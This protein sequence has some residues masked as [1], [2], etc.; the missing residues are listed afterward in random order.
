MDHQ[1]LYVKRRVVNCCS[2]NPRTVRNIQRLYTA[3]CFVL[4]SAVA[5]AQGQTIRG[6]VYEAAG[7][8]SIPYANVKLQETGEVTATNLDGYFQFND[9]PSGAYVVEV[10]YMGFQP[11]EIKVKSLPNRPYTVEVYMK[12]DKQMLGTV[13]VSADR[14]ERKNKVNTSVV[15]LSP[16]T[17]ETFSAGGDPDLMKAL[18]VLPGVVTTGDQGGQLY[19]RGGA[20]IQ[21]LVMLDGMIIYNPFHS[22]GFFSVFDTDIIQSADV[23]TA[24]FG[25]EYGSRNSSVMDVKT[26][27]GNRKELTGKWYSSTFMS[28]LLLQ[29]PLGPKNKNGLSNTSFFVSGKTSY[30]REVAPVLYPY[31]QT[32]LGGLPFTFNDVY[33]KVSTQSKNGSNLNLSGFNFSD[34]VHLDSNRAIMWDSYGYGAKFQLVPPASATIIEGN[35][36]QS[37]YFISSTENASQPRNS[38]ISGFNAGLDFTYFMGKRD[39]LKYGIDL[40]G[41]STIFNYTN[42]LGLKLNQS[43][44]TTEMAGFFNYRYVRDRIIVEPGIRL[45]YYGSLSELSVEPRFGLKYKVNELLRFKASAGKYSQNLVAANS[46][47]D[48]VNLFY[49]FLSGS[50]DLPSSFRDEPI[51]SKLQKA[52][53]AV[54][55][56]EYDLGDYWN[57]NFE[58]YIKDFSQITNINRNKLYEDIPQYQDRPEILRKDFIVERGLAYGFDMV[59]KYEYDRFY[60]WAVYAWSKVT[61]DDGIQVYAPN[62]DRRHNINL[63][64][65][66]TLGKEKKWFASV[67]WNFGS[68]FPF[69]PTAGYYPGLDFLDPYGNPDI[70]FDYTTANGDP[71]VLYG[72]LNSSRLPYYHRL[73][74]S[75]KYNTTTKYG[76]LEWSMGATNIYNR[77]NIFYYDRVNAQRVDQLPIL[78]TVSASLTF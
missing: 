30:L 26:K 50:T 61:R 3:L 69:T 8:A 60:L 28:K 24:G 57:L 10:V 7:G 56:V 46:D 43:E 16:K 33:A 36:A 45:H 51:T 15:K 9:V 78:P 74:A 1:V 47:R 63:V 72:N 2:L 58:T 22:I 25:A 19:I 6:F 5:F 23:Y 17:I 71:T 48:V 29:G 64:G 66:M 38:T 53:H 4:L 12:Q 18:A 73:D 13:D 59:A 20:P 70:N 54:A 65:N 77:N 40:V 35:F 49:G 76:D 32:Q 11:Q 14:M 62:F 67:R 52:N 21:N 75:I 41:Y 31:I 34:A 68:G 42:S 44:N 27:A 55:G 39:E 37:Q